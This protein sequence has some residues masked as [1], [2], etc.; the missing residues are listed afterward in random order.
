M[1]I[2]FIAPNY[3][4]HIGGVERHIESICREIL[5]DNHSISILVQKFDNSYSDYERN[6]N[7]EIIR[8][9]KSSKKIVRKIKIATYMLLNLKKILKY[10]II[11][12]HDY[13]T[14]W[15]Y[16]LFVYPMLKLFGKKIYITFH[17]WEGDIPPKKSIIFKRKLITAFTTANVSVGH[18]ISKWYST[19]PDIVSYG[20]VDRVDNL[21]QNKELYILFV[22]RLASDTGIFDCVKAWEIMSKDNNLE[23]VICGDGP[24][25][26]E[27]E[28]YVNKYNIQRV[29][30]KGYV[31]NVS[32]YIKDAKII[33]TSGYLGILE[34]LS[35]QKNV[36]AIYDN[37]LKKDYLTMIPNY[38]EMMWVTDNR[39]ENI[40]SVY[41]DVIINNV[42]KEIGYQYACKNSWQKVKED[43]YKL[44]E[45]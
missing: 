18:F 3:L 30:F 32:S 2:L 26:Q 44:W 43:Y 45:L 28:N 29:V 41:H 22:G 10:D 17:G 13:E 7:L 16:G 36:I 11:H 5:K 24:L 1:K 35:Y 21:S 33:F 9:N 40:I 6:N 42:K 34:A 37:E 12:F 31:N 14:F 4:P 23:L 8:L 15:A 39:M 25:R 20:G 19:K 38:E 27:V